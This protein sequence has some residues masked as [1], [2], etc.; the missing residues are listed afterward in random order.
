[1]NQLIERL[2]KI[3]TS[4]QNLMCAIDSRLNEIDARH[5]EIDI[6]LEEIRIETEIANQKLNDI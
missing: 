3:A 6:R 2:Y 4:N 1:M 5:K